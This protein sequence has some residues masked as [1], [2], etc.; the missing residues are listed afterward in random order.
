ML[1]TGVGR[2]RGVRLE[3]E[4]VEVGISGFRREK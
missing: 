1:G 4:G 2:G 3:V